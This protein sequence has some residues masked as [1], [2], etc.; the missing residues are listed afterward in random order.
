MCT[1]LSAPLA[2]CAPLVLSAL[3]VA[4]RIHTAQ[5]AVAGWLGDSPLVELDSNDEPP[6]LDTDIGPLVIYGLG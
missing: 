4:C 5:A 6:L 2:V 1:P 3:V